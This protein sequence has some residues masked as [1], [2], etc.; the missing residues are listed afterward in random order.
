MLSICNDTVHYGENKCTVFFTLLQT[1]NCNV[2]CD[3][4]NCV[5]DFCNT[6]EE[7]FYNK[8]LPTC[9]KIA[10]S[11]KKCF[12][13]DGKKITCFTGTASV[14]KLRKLPKKVTQL[15]ILCVS[16]TFLYIAMQN[17]YVTT[18]ANHKT[19]VQ[20]RF[21]FFDAFITLA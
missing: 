19:N 18:T 6:F 15:D 12:C 9:C 4:V 2:S 21:T 13:T 10:H 11:K 16:P 1:L 5:Y 8:Q 20:M 14:Y 7:L 17:S 3:K